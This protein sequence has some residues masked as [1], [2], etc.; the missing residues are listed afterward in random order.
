MEEISKNNFQKRY[1]DKTGGKLYQS[2]QTQNYPSFHSTEKAEMLPMY[3]RKQS[4][5]RTHI[6]THKLRLDLKIL[7]KILT[8]TL[9]TRWGMSKLSFSRKQEWLKINQQRQKTHEVIHNRGWRTPA[10]WLAKQP[11]HLNTTFVHGC[12]SALTSE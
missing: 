11:Y 3:F 6:H 4:Q 1:Q 7:N 5:R 12:F 10:H 9:L 2:F 8:N